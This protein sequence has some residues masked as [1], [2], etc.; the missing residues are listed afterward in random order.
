MKV[1]PYHR[2]VIKLGTNLLTADTGQL[3][4]KIMA[5]LVEQVV[6]L[7]HRGLEPVI[8]S[9][10]AIAAGRHKL[11]LNNER[12]DIPFRQVL[13]SVG[14]GYL[15]RTYEELFGQHHITVAQAL[16]TRIDMSSRAGYLNARNTILA[17]LELRVVPIINEND[18]VA[19]DE[20]GEEQFGDNDNLSATVANLIDADLLMILGDVA[21]LYSTDPNLDS[22]A[23]L[24]H[25]VEKIDAGVR[26]LARGASG[27]GTG[28]M[29][30]KIEAAKLATASGTVVVIADGREPDIITRLAE[31]EEV[32]TLFAPTTSRM[33]S[34]KRWMLS[35]ISSKGSL[36]IDAGAAAALTKQN[37]SLLPA[38][39]KEVNGEFKRGDVVDIVDAEGNRIA[40]GISNYSSDAIVITKGA[41]SSEIAALLGYEYGAEVVHRNNLVML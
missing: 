13:A 32:G 28:G 35:G 36:V 9:S 10:G 26:R 20:L 15:L 23:R 2:I 21:G 8:V 19:T 30:T 33:E 18:V 1:T 11:G 3:D 24:V 27:S 7:H 12:K 31:G 34:R 37:R 38:G 40:R 41:R 6:H 25:R 5:S 4:P 16:L 17:L 22:D 39:I 14:Q 29:I